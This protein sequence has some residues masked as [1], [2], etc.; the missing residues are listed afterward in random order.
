[1]KRPAQDRPQIDPGGILE[2]I[3]AAKTAETRAKRV[4]TAAIEASQGRRAN[5]WQRPQIK[6]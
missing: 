2:W 4:E 6:P 5:Q 3:G 1:M